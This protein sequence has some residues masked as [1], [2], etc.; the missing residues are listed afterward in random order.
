MNPSPNAAS[1]NPVVVC[2]GVQVNDLIFTG[3]GTSYNWTNNLSSIGLA[4]SGTNQISSFIA[5]NTTSSIQ[6]ANIAVTPIY[7]GGGATCSGPITN[8]TI[9]VNPTPTVTL[10]NDLAFCN[11][12]V[13]P[14]LSFSGSGSS[15]NWTNS[16]PS[17]GLLGSGSGSIQSFSAINNGPIPLVATIEVTPTYTYAGVKKSGLQWTEPLLEIKQKVESITGAS[18][19]ACLLNLYHEGEEGMGWHRD[20]EKEI[21]KE[22]TKNNLQTLKL[23]KLYLDQF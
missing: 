4:T 9:S 16:N 3:T 11:S 13:A 5:S 15:Y 17:I 6:T 23:N 1:V 20:N 22:Q 2:N 12:A 21:V 7:Q 18:Y 10:T 14:Q 19:N 8:F